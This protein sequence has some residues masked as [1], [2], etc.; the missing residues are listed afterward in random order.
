[1]GILKRPVNCS[2]VSVAGLG[3]EPGEYWDRVV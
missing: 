2:L 1:M 3:V